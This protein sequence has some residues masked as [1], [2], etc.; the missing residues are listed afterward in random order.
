[1][2][3][4][5]PGPMSRGRGGSISE[6]PCSA[7]PLPR[8]PVIGLRYVDPKGGG[9]NTSRRFRENLPTPRQPMISTLFNWPPTEFS[10]SEN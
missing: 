10:I 7:L 2:L 1:M 9:V 8:V 6:L 5:W 3:Q 4:Q